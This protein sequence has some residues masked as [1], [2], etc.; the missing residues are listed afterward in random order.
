M[1]RL[2]NKYGALKQEYTNSTWEVEKEVY[3]LF[4]NTLPEDYTLAEM[5]VLFSEFIN[6]LHCRMAEDLLK[7]AMD[8]RKQE[9]ESLVNHF[10]VDEI[11]SVI[12]EVNNKC[13]N[14]AGKI[15]RIKTVRLITSLGLIDAKKFVEDHWDN[16][17]VAL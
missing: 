10:S 16:P 1:D 3:Q 14:D 5:R 12:T 15:E 2:Y 7:K 4:L 9:R 13:G 8:M 11:D 17:Y 6:G